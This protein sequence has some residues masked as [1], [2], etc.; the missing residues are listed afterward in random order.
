VEF[1]EW[2]KDGLL[3][4]PIFQ[5][6]R[7]DKTSSEVNKEKPVKEAALLKKAK[8][9]PKDFI[10]NTD[11][12][13]WPKEKYTKGDL[14]K[15]Y[16]EIAPYILPYL[17]D[18][19]EVLHRFPDGIKGKHFYQKEA[20][21]FIP[22]WMPTATVEHSDRVI[23]YLL[24]NDLKSLLYT[25]NLG[26]I[27][28]HPFTSQISK[29]DFPDYVV[30]DLDPE[31][32]SFKRVIE[33]AKILHGILKEARLKHYCKT[34]GKRGLHVVIPLGKKYHYDQAEAFAH[35]IAKI[36][37][38]EYPKATSL[39]R[40]PKRRQRKVYID[41]LQ[42]SRTKTIVAPYSVRPV[43]K[44]SVSAPLHWEEVEEGLNPSQFTIKTMIKRLRKEG[45]L[46]KPMLKEKIDMSQ[47]ISRL[48]KL[49]I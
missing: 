30:L 12:I 17:F 4:Q 18:R 26:C 22:E 32:V 15:Y 48:E 41:Y 49:L 19:P 7:E 27:E 37:H 25:V 10:T 34:S 23:N 11:K 36:A 6:L 14:L 28:L 16:E 9:S 31:A 45:D 8:S 42:N 24:V 44:A 5:R 13:F 40:D 47:A 35:L 46:F 21:D 39:L 1:Q 2:T 38:L 29:I 43:P 3:R 33:T 20:P